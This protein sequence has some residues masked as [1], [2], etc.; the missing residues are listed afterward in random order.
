VNEA[1]QNR[2]TWRGLLLVSREVPPKAAGPTSRIR[3][4]ISRQPA[5]WCNQVNLSDDAQVYGGVPEPR[6]IQDNRD[7]RGAIDMYDG[8]RGQISHALIAISGISAM[9]INDYL[10]RCL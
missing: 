2:F 10:V 5:L 7:L 9:T 6:S 8:G 3:Q 1:G 4:R